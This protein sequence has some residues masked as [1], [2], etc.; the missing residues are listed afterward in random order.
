MWNSFGD[1]CT[2]ARCN[3]PALNQ[4]RGF[5]FSSVAPCVCCRGRDRA[6]SFACGMCM[7]YQNNASRQDKPKDVCGQTRAKKKP[8]DI[9]VSGS[10][11]LRV[12][13]RTLFAVSKSIV[14][15]FN[16]SDDG[17]AGGEMQQCGKGEESEIAV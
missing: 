7:A 3:R 14:T 5:S 16:K 17:E 12:F 2:T 15:G 10:P 9:H 4:A 11:S 6:H 13:S 8:R 1:I